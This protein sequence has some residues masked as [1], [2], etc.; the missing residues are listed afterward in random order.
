METSVST[1][2]AADRLLAA[3]E[4]LAAPVCVG[5]DPVLERLPAS[6]KPAA[7]DTGS[8]VAAIGSF[9]EGVLDAVAEH[10]PCVKFQSACF[11]R[12]RGPGVQTLFRLIG[13]ARRRGPQ[14]ILDAK[15]GDIGISAAHYAAA[16]FEPPVDRCDER[17]DWITVST[18]LGPDSLEPFV[19]PDRGVFALVR[20]SNPGG[21][22]LQDRRLDTG[23]TVAEAVGAMVAELGRGGVGS[24]GYSAVGAVVAATRPAAAA[25]LRRLMP[26]QIFLVPGFGAQGGGVD[27]VRS[28]F[29]SDGTGAI[30]TAS[31]SVIYGPDDAGPAWEQAVGRRAQALAEQVGR[32]AGLR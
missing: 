13:S 27:Q 6:L 18:Y 5:I 17:P 20:T 1:P 15:R 19:E 31:R 9:V 10:V 23:Q 16:T 7:A 12:Y 32:V 2:H 24:R 3:V 28:C 4:R 11:E 26:Q 8:A 25:S 22:L 30:V 21:D 14:V 29:G